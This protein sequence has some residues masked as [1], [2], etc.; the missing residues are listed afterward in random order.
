MQCIYTFSPEE[1]ILYTSLRNVTISKPKHQG[2]T[3]QKP[4]D[5]LTMAEYGLKSGP[6]HLGLLLSEI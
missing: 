3:E 2:L 1:W 4:L 6:V 5:K